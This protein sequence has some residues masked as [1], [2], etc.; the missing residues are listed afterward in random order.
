ML[1]VVRDND[2]MA[3]VARDARARLERVIA[4]VG[5]TA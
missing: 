3:E 2:T 5:R 1:G 4:A